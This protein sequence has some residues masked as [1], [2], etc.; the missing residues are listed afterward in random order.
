MINVCCA[1]IELHTNEGGTLILA[2]RKNNDSHLAGLWE[3]PGG[4]LEAGESAEV[5]I[6]REIREELGCEIHTLIP[7]PPHEHDYGTHAIRLIPFICN[8]SDN[9]SFPTYR[10]HAALAFLSS[11]NLEKL[12]WAP[13]DLPIM[14]KYLGV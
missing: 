5:A 1:L 14:R 6:V 9:S 4:K 13:A 10:E 3:F 7:L 8:L 2:A 12:N 11:R